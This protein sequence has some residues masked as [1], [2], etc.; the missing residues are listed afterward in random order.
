MKR[1]D[2]QPVPTTTSIILA[3][4]I[5][6]LC[7]AGCA[8]HVGAPKEQPTSVK[9]VAGPSGSLHVDDGGSGGIPVVF[10]HSFAGSTEH[11]S[12]QLA[13][14][15]K[16]RRAVALDLHGHGQSARRA[17]ETMRS[18]LSPRTLAPSR[19][20]WGSSVSYWWGTASEARRRSRMRMRIR[21]ASRDF[22]WSLRL[23]RRRRIKPR[24]S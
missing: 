12:A 22:C 19:I 10:V 21:I 6:V 20:G 9:Q 13:H 5:A 8:R 17:T 18:S 24:R 2:A 14:L 3:C 7:F 11:W 16:T 1:F 23:E 4:A 15:R